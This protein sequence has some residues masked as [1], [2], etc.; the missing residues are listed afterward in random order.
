MLRSAALSAARRVSA[1]PRTTAVLGKGAVFQVRDREIACMNHRAPVER[2]SRSAYSLWSWLQRGSSGGE[3]SSPSS[4]GTT[5]ASTD[6]DKA[7]IDCAWAWDHR[8]V[9]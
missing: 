7:C 9:N 1:Q 2:Q 6:D 5:S 8:Y 4:P 3:S